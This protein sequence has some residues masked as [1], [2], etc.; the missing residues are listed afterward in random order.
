[1]HASYDI[2]NVCLL[3]ERCCT[4]CATR[5]GDSVM[6]ASSHCGGSSDGSVPGAPGLWPVWAPVTPHGYQ[7]L[8]TTAFRASPT[9]V[10][11]IMDCLPVNL[12]QPDIHLLCFTTRISPGPCLWGVRDPLTSFGAVQKPWIPQACTVR[13]TDSTAI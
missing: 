5:G 6:T 7:Y 10:L 3:C 1:M 11:S 8:C 12:K 13:A 2:A 9:C 4:G